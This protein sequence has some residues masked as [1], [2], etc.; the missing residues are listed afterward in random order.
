MGLYKLF[1]SNLE[2][3]VPVRL[4]IHSLKDLENKIIGVIVA[5]LAV[6]FFGQVVATSDLAVLLHYGGGIAL[7]IAAL[8]FF[9]RQGDKENGSGADL[10]PGH[11]RSQLVD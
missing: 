7:M 6:A 4:N 1:I 8:A 10:S 11:S 2:V 9:T 5:A 3:K